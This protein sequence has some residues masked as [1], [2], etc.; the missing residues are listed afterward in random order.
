MKKRICSN[1]LI[2]LI[3]VGIAMSLLNFST[4]AYAD[5]I[6]GTTT[7]VESILL[8]DYYKMIGRWLLDHY[9]CIGDP[10][11]CCVVYAN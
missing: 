4:K 9:Y 11:T 5:A 8:E 6:Y 7:H 3:V 1:L 2:M 10:S